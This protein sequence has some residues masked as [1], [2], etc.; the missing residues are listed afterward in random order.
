MRLLLR[1]WIHA[2]EDAPTA[3]VVAM[4]EAVCR[5]ELLKGLKG[6]NAKALLPPLPGRYPTRCI[7]GCVCLI[8]CE[9]VPV[10]VKATAQQ[11]CLGM[12][13]GARGVICFFFSLIDPLLLCVLSSFP[14]LSTT[15]LSPFSPFSASYV[16]G[17]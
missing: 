7:L 8:D 4:A 11:M 3:P 16:P 6:G 5:Q 10:R 12:T 2:A 13:R 17:S 9:A 15:R 1:L 14:C